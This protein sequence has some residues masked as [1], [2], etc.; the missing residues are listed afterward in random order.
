VNAIFQ[1]AASCPRRTNPAVGG[2]RVVEFPGD[3][4]E[5]CAQVVDRELDVAS[6]RL[7]Q[8]CAFCRFSSCEVGPDDL[9]LLA[10]ACDRIIE[11]VAT[12][13]EHLL[14][15]IRVMAE[16]CVRVVLRD[17]LD[18]CPRALPVVLIESGGSILGPARA[19]CLNA[20]RVPTSH[21]RC[22]PGRPIRVLL[23]IVDAKF[24][25]DLGKVSVSRL[26]AARQ[27]SFARV[28]LVLGVGFVEGV[29]LRNDVHHTVVSPWPRG[30]KH[31]YVIRVGCSGWN[32]DHWRGRLYPPSG[33]TGK[34]LSIYAEHFDTVEVNATFYRL[35]RATAVERWAAAT[36]EEFCFA[37]KGSRYLTHVR[38]LRGPA[39]G[40]GRLDSLIEPL[41]AA[42]KLG[43]VLWQLPGNFKRDDDRL[44]R[45]LARLTSGRH[46]F[47]F[48]HSSWFADDVYSRLRDHGVALV[49]AD[50][51]PEPAPEWIETTDWA[52]LRFH[53]GRGR[54]GNY[55]RRE[56]REWA[57]R[58]GNVSG[59][60]YAYFNNDWEGFAVENA[61]A[62]AALLDLNVA[63]H[64]R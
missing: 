16:R 55:S 12:G 11:R 31:P 48:R 62:L 56:L 20:R 24:T 39:E 47:E 50:R 2:L 3:R 4:V 14:D 36:P 58:L 22:R 29:V 57:D 40:I 19:N 28:R 59:D 54:R 10:L 18:R 38:R 7:T 64:A 26:V 27:R 25:A 49:I 34:W 44:E 46:A 23:G 52:Y 37:V 21:A 13:C 41:R 61:R 33:S 5:Q 43:P 30:G 1:D 53:H 6:R 32:Y 63:A 9:R 15:E 42:D 51:G 45:F 17:L 60:V 35:P 8:L